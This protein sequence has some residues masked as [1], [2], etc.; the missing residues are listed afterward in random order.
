MLIL[1]Q[2]TKFFKLFQ[3]LYWLFLLLYPWLGFLL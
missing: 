2:V 3:N 1:V